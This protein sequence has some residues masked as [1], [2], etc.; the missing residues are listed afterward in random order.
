MR[1]AVGASVPLAGVGCAI[2]RDALAAVA[3]QRGAPFDPESLTEDYELGLRLK[4]MG[5]RS[6]FVRRPNGEGGG[7]IAAREYFPATLDGAVAQ[8]ARWM[9]GIALAAG[10]RLAGV[11]ARWSTGLRLRDRQSLLA[12]LVLARPICAYLYAA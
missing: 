3:A 9:V 6:A 2:R 8:K 11:A 7:V 12:A 5:R 1:E 10:D 4:A